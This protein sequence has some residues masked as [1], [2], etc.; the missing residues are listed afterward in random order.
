MPTGARPL[1]RNARGPFLSPTGRLLT[2]ATSRI[3][4]RPG[5]PSASRNRK[6]CSR[7]LFSGNDYN[8]GH[9]MSALCSY[10]KR[11]YRAVSACDN[12]QLV[13][14]VGRSRCGG[15]PCHRITM[16]DRIRTQRPKAFSSAAVK[17]TGPDAREPMPDA[18]KTVT[19]LFADIVD[20]SRLVDLRM[21]GSG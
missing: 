21:T 4:Q 10:E 5:C 2:T 20:S 3:A 9:R 15:I 7:S 6:T 16:P 11:P 1:H 17:P 12:P 19:V 13:S 14:G 18:R 8:A